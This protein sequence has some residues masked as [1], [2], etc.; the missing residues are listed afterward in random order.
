M[1]GK[2]RIEL[3]NERV[4]TKSGRR[5]LKNGSEEGVVRNMRGNGVVR[6]KTGNG[7]VKNKSKN[8][9]AKKSGIGTIVWIWIGLLCFLIGEATSPPP[10][11][12]I[13]GRFP[14]NGR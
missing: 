1:S 8:G 7:V 13:S 4:S 9:V 2:V 6:N 5:V 12:H 10:P 14:A 3:K 11:D